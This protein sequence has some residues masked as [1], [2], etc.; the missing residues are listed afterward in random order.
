MSGPTTL[1]AAVEK[2]LQ[3]VPNWKL[4]TMPDTTPIAN[5]TAKS[6]SQK[7]NSCSYSARPVMSHS[8]SSTAS[9]LAS[10]IVNAGNRMWND[11]TNANCRRDS[12]SGS[13][14]MALFDCHSEER[15][16]EESAERSE[17]SASR[18]LTEQQIPHVVR[19]IP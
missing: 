6:L 12:S 17:G 5:D 18:E 1:P 2:R 10:P 16:D 14:S 7:R 4:M 9:Q 11:I 13:K 8:A 15:R 3:F 19:E